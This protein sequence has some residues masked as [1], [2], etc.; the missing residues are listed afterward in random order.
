MVLIADSP[1][2]PLLLLAG[3]GDG[4]YASPQPIGLA[5]LATSEIWTVD[6]NND[7]KPDLVAAVTQGSS[8][9]YY[10][11]LNDGRGH[12]NNAPETP[13]PV[14]A[15]G[16]TVIADVTGDGLPEIIHEPNDAG[17]G[18]SLEIIGKDPFVG[19]APIME[20]GLDFTISNFLGGNQLADLNED[21]KPDFVAINFADHDDV[22]VILST[23]TGWTRGSIVL[24]LE[25]TQ[26]LGA[27]LGDFD[28]DGHVDIAVLGAPL[29]LD[30]GDSLFLLKGDGHGNFTQLPTV[31]FNR[32][33]VTGMVSGDFNGDGRTD[34]FWLL[35]AGPSD[36]GGQGF[37]NVNQLS[38][39]TFLNNGHGGFDPSTPNPVPL[40][41]AGSSIELGNPTVADLDGDG[42]PD[43]ILGTNDQWQIAQ[44]ANDGSGTMHPATA[45]L[46][47]I[48]APIAGS[49]QNNQ[50]DSMYQMFA[51]FNNDGLTDFVL[52]EANVEIY[53]GKSDGGFEHAQSLPASGGYKPGAVGDLN[54]DGIPDLLL[55]TDSGIYD[56]LVFLGNGDGTFRPAPNFRLSWGEGAVGVAYV[57]L[58]D[59]NN[60]GNLD[61]VV[62]LGGDPDAHSSLNGQIAICFGDGTGKLIYNA[63]T[64]FSGL[65]APALA[66]FDQDGKLDLIVTST[67]TP[68]ADYE[69]RFYRGKGNGLFTPGP[70]IATFP[71]GGNTD[72]V[73]L[74]GDFNGDGN[75]DFFGKDAVLQ[76]Y[77]GDGHGSFQLDSDLNL[78]AGTHPTV[79]DFNGDGILDVAEGHDDQSTA[80]YLGDA[81]GHFAGPMLSSFGTSFN[82]IATA[83]LKAPIAAGSFAI[84]DHAPVATDVQVSGLAGAAVTIL[85]V[86]HT[87]DPDNET[88][89]VTTLSKP[90]HGTVHLDTNGT[91]N[92]FADDAIL[93][94]ADLGYSGTDTFT[95]TVADAA[96]LEATATITVTVAAQPVPV[97]QFSASAY[98]VGE[99]DGVATITVTRTGST[100][101]TATVHFATSDGTA[102]A[103]SDY[104][105]AS[106]TLTFA[107]REASK[108]FTISI[109]N[110]S[111]VE[112]NETVILT[113]TNPSGTGARLGSQA[114]SVL[115]I[116]DN[117]APRPGMLQ[118]SSAT[119]QVVESGTGDNR[120]VPRRWQRRRRFGRV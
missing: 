111:L 28:G 12:F 82:G 84:T 26:H 99:G 41:A 47:F 97:L 45:S 73:F 58:G 95:Y 9:Y 48:G 43:V 39:W 7:R 118:F 25:D 29:G 16:E 6:W 80:V 91:P 40:A 5:G 89:H 93:Y 14:A 109:T 71:S 76:F 68:G 3:K 102:L 49:G 42:F 1:T 110:D 33:D 120:R 53:L 15:I 72:E 96:G 107:D 54:H 61:A 90:V 36:F 13:I 63:N 32:R 115:T 50:D 81:T 67:P 57:S 4:T 38:G 22:I 19:Y 104:T 108:T 106:G 69:V 18:L 10:V 11:L 52:S 55:I 70:V 59:V 34:M 64:L 27:S 79:G 51:D 46:P 116:V 83:P 31:V 23:P 119:Y 85:I 75:L 94:T 8:S 117:D 78:P 112:S 105:A 44:A 35:A 74:V 114:T 92:D 2:D 98:S 100:S 37:D 62:T 24:G 77:R 20:S 17:A 65:F 103:G 60:D 30:T 101:G 88:P 66:D 56:M 87:T 86:P 113:L 21:G